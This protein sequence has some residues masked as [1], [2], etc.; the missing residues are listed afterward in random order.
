[1]DRDRAAE[2]LLT[3]WVRCYID[4]VSEQWLKVAPRAN[5]AMIEIFSDR[6]R[7][8]RRFKFTA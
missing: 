4:A 3:G 1:M 7:Q 8:P 6:D 5:P 2:I